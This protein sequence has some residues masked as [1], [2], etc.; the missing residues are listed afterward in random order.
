MSYGT[1][2]NERR[3]AHDFV[4]IEGVH[5]GQKIGNLSKHGGKPT[6]EYDQGTQPLESEAGNNMYILAEVSIHLGTEFVQVF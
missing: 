2:P 5:V 6:H 4:K 1:H 3:S